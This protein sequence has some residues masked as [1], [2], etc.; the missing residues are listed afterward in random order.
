M[1]GLSSYIG[2]CTVWNKIR[3]E[4]RKKILFKLTWLIHTVRPNTVAGEAGHVRLERPIDSSSDKTVCAPKVAEKGRYSRDLI[5]KPLTDPDFCSCFQ[6]VLLFSRGIWEI[7]AEFL[8]FFVQNLQIISHNSC[9][10]SLVVTHI[11]TSSFWRLYPPPPT[12]YRVPSYFFRRTAYRVKFYW[13]TKYY[14]CQA[15]SQQYEPYARWNAIKTL[16]DD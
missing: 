5:N 14:M 1:V 4:L 2:S 13:R 10:W 9:H 3:S 12:A 11:W 6:H 8:A 7:H 15:F 16:A